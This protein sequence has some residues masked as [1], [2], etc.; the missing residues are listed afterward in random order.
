MPD[1]SY[2]AP[3]SQRW[4]TGMGCKGRRSVGLQVQPALALEQRLQLG[5]ERVQVQHIA[6]RIGALLGRRSGRAPVAGL[7][8]LADLDAQQVAAEILSPCRSV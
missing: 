1:P 8:L 5:P 6:R 4:P 3:L 7:L 2:V